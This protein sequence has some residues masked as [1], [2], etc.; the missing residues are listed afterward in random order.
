[1]D[2]LSLI[3]IPLHSMKTVKTLIVVIFIVLFCFNS[4]AKGNMPKAEPTLSFKENKGQLCDQFAKPRPDILFSGS[5][6]N[7][8]FYLRNNGVSYQMYR[9]NSNQTTTYRLDINWLN[10][11]NNA[12]VLKETELEGYDNYYTEACPN[13]ITNVKAYKKITYQNLYE[14]INLKWYEKDGNLKY[15]YIVEPGIDYKKIQLEVK[16]AESISVDKNGN[17]LIKTPLGTLTEKTPYV[18]QDNKI[19]KSKW[20]VT[21]NIISFSITNADPSKTLVIDPLVR[22]WGTYYGG[23]ADDRFF[24]S[25]VDASGNIYAAGYSDALVNIATIGAYQTVSGGGPT[26]PGPGR[27]DDAIL[28]KFN[29]AGVRLW[30]TYYGGAQGEIG[31]NC[32]LDPS[33]N[34][35]AMAGATSSTLSGVIATAGAHQTTFGGSFSSALGDAFLVVF[36]NAGIRQWGTYYGGKGTETGF[37]CNFDI[38]G[39]VYL[40]GETTSTTNIAS[41]GAHQTTHGG[42]IVSDGYIAKFNNTGARLWATY[43]GGSFFDRLTGCISD[44]SGNVFVNGYSKSNNNISAGGAY[45]PMYAG[46][47]GFGDAVIAKFNS[48]GTRLWG[49]YYGGKGDDHSFNCVLDANGNLYVAGVTTVGSQTTITTSGAHQ[50]TFGGNSYDAYLLKLSSGGTRLWCTLYGG[51]GNESFSWCSVDPLG[52]VY[53]SGCTESTNNISTPCSYQPNFAGVID[54]YLAKFDSNGTRQWGTYYGGSTYDDFCASS[55]DLLGNVY[56]VGWT[57]SYTGIASPGSHQPVVGGIAN[58]INGDGFL[59][60]FDGCIPDAPNTTDP[61]DMAMCPGKFTVLTTSVTSCVAWYNVAVGGY[62]I[63]NTFSLTT[64][65][66]LSTTTFYISDESCGSSSLRTPVT[67]TIHPKP[68]AEFNYSPLKPIIDQNSE[69]SFYDATYGATAIQWDWYFMNTPSPH[70]SLQNP[71]FIYSDAGQYNVVLVV[72][73]DKGCKDTIVKSIE[74]LE[75]HTFYVPNAFTPN[76]DGLND[77]FLPKGVAVTKYELRIFNRLG[78]E[79][80]FTND[81]ERGWDGIYKGVLCKEDT[82]VWK[83]NFTNVFSKSYSLTGHVTLLK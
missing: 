1:M 36:N 73:S 18:T 9:L 61:S 63:S 56:L 22:L 80:M 76:G 20:I 3:R 26:G 77:V 30:G 32:A 81:F 64:P 74:V 7:S 34:F 45:Q 52:N 54:C 28:V 70:S 58:G 19:L 83:I 25:V 57:D 42:G 51:S 14:G 29:A 41:P 24:N 38:N 62:S 78:E 66:L 46:P 39:D 16:G 11:T 53:L 71:S 47:N 10:V 37:G 15:D 2:L 68:I 6:G 4:N 82:Y 69:V 72:T 60:K 48:S 35:I 27:S 49:T 50:T 55:T 59:V 12:S 44:A 75:D 5:N 65:E 67:V 21:K 13:G 31:Q 79:L 43:Y 8:N 33:G 23:S 17:L 40:V